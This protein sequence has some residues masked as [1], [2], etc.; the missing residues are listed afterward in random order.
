MKDGF[1]AFSVDGNK[2][3]KMI[4]NSGGITFDLS[5]N[6]P[7][8]EPEM[9]TIFVTLQRYSEEQQI[10]PDPRQPWDDIANKKWDPWYDLESGQI[11]CVFYVFNDKIIARTYGILYNYPELLTYVRSYIR[12]D[13]NLLTNINGINIKEKN[14]FSIDRV[15]VHP[16]HRGQKL[17]KPLLSFF[18]SYLTNY[19]SVKVSL[20]YNASAVLDGLP[21]CICYLKAGEIND[22]LLL[23][24]NGGEITHK[25]C[26]KLINKKSK[27]YYYVSPSLFDITDSG[28]LQTSYIGGKKA[29][30]KKKKKKTKGI[31]IK[32]NKSR[33]G[34]HSRTYKKYRINNKKQKITLRK[35]KKNKKSYSKKNVN[36][37]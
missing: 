25:N 12:S 34:K 18:L 36:I 22:L 35:K 23:G 30:K 19:E 9:E 1:Y 29:N 5:N 8:D 4:H 21:A 10:T 33:R 31:A 24:K 20:L 2:C 6:I 14:I 17:C 3:V 11:K 26:G 28:E 15:D 32:T 13:I 37:E 7:L 16:E 27:I